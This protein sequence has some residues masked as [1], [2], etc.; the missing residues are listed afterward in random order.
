MIS[1]LLKSVFGSRNDRLLKQYRRN[2]DAI[3]ALEAGIA[4][5]TDDELRNKTSQFKQRVQQGETLDAL[6]PEAFAV[7]REGGRRALQMRHFD[8]QLVGGMV[9]HYGKIA[10]MRTGEGKTLM[11]TLPAYLNALSGKGVH[12]VTVNDYLAA[13]DAEWMGRLYRFLGL[14]VG[15]ILSNMD[16]GDKQA[17]YAADIT[18]GTNNEFGFDYLRDNMAAQANER[19]Q[20]GLNFA[21]VDEVDSILIDEARTPLII[22]GQAEDNLDV[23]L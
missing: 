5:L 8:V 12:V 23:Y 18:Y 1:K 21:I 22:S 17:A 19:F 13:R 14:S 9:L 6:L 11:A 20:H 15:V 10:E 3:N 16:H 7:V 2:V 4:A